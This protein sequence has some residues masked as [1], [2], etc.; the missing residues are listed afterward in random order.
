MCH[1]WPTVMGTMSMELQIQ[2]KACDGYSS[3]ENND[4]WGIRIYH[5]GVEINMEVSLQTNPAAVM[6]GTSV[7]CLS[8]YGAAEAS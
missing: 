1:S 8:F 4:A 2:A 6:K 7:P 3:K 5:I